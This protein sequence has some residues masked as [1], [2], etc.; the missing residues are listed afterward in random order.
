MDPF[1][2]FLFSM[3]SHK[4]PYNFPV[5]LALGFVTVAMFKIGIP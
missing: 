5:I 2:P 4:N 3:V 1:L